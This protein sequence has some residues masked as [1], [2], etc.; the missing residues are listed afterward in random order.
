MYGT[1]AVVLAVGLGI[2]TLTWGVRYGATGRPLPVSD[3]DR[4]MNLLLVEDDAQTRLG[5]TIEHMDD[6]AA[7][8]PGVEAIGAWIWSFA[9]LSREDAPA[10]RVDAYWTTSELFDILEIEPL[11]GR[12]LRP[13][14]SEPGAHPVTVLGHDYWQTEFGGDPRAIGTVVRLDGL[15]FE[16]VGVLPPDKGLTGNEDF[17][18]A[19]GARGDRE[20]RRYE[21]LV[22]L[23]PGVSGKDIEERLAVLAEVHATEG[24]ARW[25]G[26]RAMPFRFGDVFYT[27][28]TD[29]RDRVLWSGGILLFIM[30]LANVANLFL[31][32]ARTRARE[33]AIRRVLGAA[34]PRLFRQLAVESLIPAAVGFMGA[35]AIAAFTLARYQTAA[36]AYRAGFLWQVY[37]LERPHVFLLAIG[38][39]ASTVFV[40]VVTARRELR[41]GR[42]R[43]LGPTDG[44][45]W[46]GFRLGRAFV[47][48]QVAAGI[49]LLL[50]A[51]LMTRS[52][53]NQRTFEFGF[54][55]DDVMTADVQLQGALYDDASARVAFW[56]QLHREL[57]E[58]QGVRRASV[59]A[60]L[61]M[62]RCCENRF[63]VEIEGVDVSGLRPF[64]VLY[65]NA[66]G[67]TYF[68]TFDAPPL[69]G[70]G[71]AP[72][73]RTED[74]P[75][76]MVNEPLVA[77]YYGGESALGRR[78]RVWRGGQP[79]P[80]RKIVGVAPH[81]WM[82]TDVN[83]SPEGVY[84]P[85]DQNPP[86][87]ASLA[88][89]VWGDPN[90][91]ADELRAAVGRVD[92]EQP[93]SF[94][95]SMPQLFRD[96]T[97]LYRREGPLFTQLGLAGLLL[98]VVGLYS[99][100]W[101]MTSLSV[102][103]LGLRAALGAG[104]QELVWHAVKGVA[105]PTG[106]G[107]LLG[108]G[109][110]LLLTRRLEP[111]VFLVD[112]W[113]PRVAVATGLLMGVCAMVASLGPAVRASRAD[114]A[115]VLVAE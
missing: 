99:A 56:S 79:G 20:T 64:P 97:G 15:S 43:S 58:I 47:G 82:D 18:I 32:T 86:A 101:H 6:I 103:E 24:E 48:I 70:R 49:A 102:R 108:L 54:S 35:A 110:G 112:P 62:I 96:R 8:V 33:I 98:A 66:V 10:V 73:D 107:S 111:F 83:R 38:T 31:V 81:L 13:G 39:L 28:T 26:V 91:F 27:A 22:R 74:V 75:L 84:I 46:A 72:S 42:V 11:H 52:A 2:A 80:W 37:R 36:D 67:P 85:L 25:R 51:S 44:G 95:R 104:R 40:S 69:E 53:W 105:M 17:W 4:V 93:V 109:V 50:V 114:P 7:D 113:D 78:V 71:F 100:V 29:V 60:Q 76:A 3:P 87:R 88:V 45:P 77:R 12:L 55:G 94:V 68:D 61:P 1:A 34:Q 41:G 92:P 16:V 106:C 19:G 9:T 59:G 5:L 57:E 89:R 30:T 90:D 14:D 21:V 23:M 65:V 115:R 63:P